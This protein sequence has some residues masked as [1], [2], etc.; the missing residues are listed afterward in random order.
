[1]L[2]HLV[3]PRILKHA[4]FHKAILVSV[5]FGLM[6]VLEDGQRKDVVHQLFMKI[7][8]IVNVITSHSFL[9]FNQLHVK[10]HQSFFPLTVFWG[11]AF[12]LVVIRAGLF[13][14]R[15]SGWGLQHRVADAISLPAALGLCSLFGFTFLL[16]FILTLAYVGA[17]E[18]T[19]LEGNSL[20]VLS[21]SL[22]TISFALVV[23]EAYRSYARLLSN[24]TKRYFSERARL[25]VAALFGLL[26]GEYVV[27]GSASDL[28][29]IYGIWSILDFIYVVILA[30]L[31]RSPPQAKDGHGLPDVSNDVSQSSPL[32]RPLIAE[33]DPDAF[34]LPP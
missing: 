9:W 2:L 13:Y 24:G 22:F 26:V 1:M 18:L 10:A 30:L 25:V 19:I 17:F 8:S 31:S 14:T 16:R 6:K 20:S 12:I 34:L 32:V 4:L 23:F 3:H 11:L 29:V 5:V 28:R 21:L 27:W 33:G 7:V 15:V